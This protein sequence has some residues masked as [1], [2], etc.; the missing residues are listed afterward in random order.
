VLFLI[1]GC[2][3]TG[4]RVAAGL[5]TEGHAV[6][7][8]SRHPERLALPG[9]RCLRLDLDDPASVV[10][11]GAA[12]PEGIRVL[13]SIPLIEDNVREWSDPTPRLLDALGG[14][15]ER[16]VYLSTTG[17]YGAQVQVN[18]LTLPAPRGPREQLRV[19]AERAVQAGPWASMVLR[20]AAIYGPGRGV[21]QSMRRGTFRLPGDGTRFI[22]RIHVDDLAALA[23]AALLSRQTGAWPVADEEPCSSLEICRFVSDLTGLPMPQPAP[24]GM[25]SE[26]LRNNR[27]V[28]GRAVPRLLRVRL[29]YASYRTG[30]PACLD[31]ERDAERDG[32]SASPD[33]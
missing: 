22:S 5:A 2:G 18:E 15:P 20:P 32:V 24:P 25:V 3:F 19:D 21:Q 28:D 11:A 16:L 13:L 6:W 1:L 4:R 26:T 29:R 23:R 9:V 17:V 14:K 27:Q 31:A 7:A 12:I 10:C 30:I 33:R 8:T